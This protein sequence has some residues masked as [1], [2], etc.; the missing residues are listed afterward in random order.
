ME[1]VFS[2]ASAAKDGI[3]PYFPRI[4]EIL[5]V[6]LTEEQ[7]DETLCLQIQAVGKHI[8]VCSR[9]DLN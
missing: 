2:T 4:I 5:K 8:A 3:V 7:S 6:Y 1:I 9:L